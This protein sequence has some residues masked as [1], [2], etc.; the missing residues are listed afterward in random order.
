VI[1][2][3]IWKLQVIR[4]LQGLSVSIPVIVLIFHASGLSMQ[5]VFTI[6]AWFAI[7]VIM[8]EIPSGYF[9]D[10][11]G[12]KSAIVVGTLFVCLGF[13]AYAF[14]SGFWMFLL[15]ETVLGIGHSFLSGADSAML[16]DTLMQLGISTEYRRRESSNHSLRI[17]SEGVA[18]VFGGILAAASLFVP[19][20]VDA[21][22]AAISLGIAFSLVE[23]EAVLSG[24]KI[25]QPR[26]VRKMI[27]T[28]QN[29]VILWISAYSAIVQCSTL[30]MF[31]LMQPYLTAMHVPVFLYGIIFAVLLLIGS[32]SVW[33]LEPIAKSLGMRAV[34]FALVLF[35]SVSYISLGAIHEIWSGIFLVLFYVVRGFERP[36]ILDVMNRNIGSEMRAAVLSM[37]GLMTKMIFVILGPIVG[38]VHDTGSLHAAFLFS[39]CVFTISGMSILNILNRKDIIPER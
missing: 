39:G 24:A 19:L 14:A 16:Y 21:I 35:P 7:V 29:P 1:G 6:Q 17:F 9:A 32:I 4:G 23:P 15:A 22:I 38:L 18:S 13:C 36:A 10:M 5:D 34:F 31:W 3:N 37:N 8:C 27:K 25:S 11:Y 30:T 20:Y 2:N 12:R 26:N 28:V 33:C